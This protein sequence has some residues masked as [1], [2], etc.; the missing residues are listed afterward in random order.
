M[1]SIYAFLSICSQKYSHLP[2][3]VEADDDV[4]ISLRS[5]PAVD[6]LTIWKYLEEGMPC[7]MEKSS[8][9]LLTWHCC[10]L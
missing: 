7:A 2:L 5:K 3:F 8:P 1:F 6:D 9:L 4:A 10:V